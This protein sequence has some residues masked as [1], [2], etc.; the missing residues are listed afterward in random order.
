MQFTAIF[1]TLT[2]A[3]SVLAAPVPIGPVAIAGG[4]VAGAG[5]VCAFQG[6]QCQAIGDNVRNTIGDAVDKVDQ[7]LPEGPGFAETVG[8][9]ISSVMGASKV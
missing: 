9:A 4:I 8:N 3:A 2:A 7:A 5:A 1:L 6:N